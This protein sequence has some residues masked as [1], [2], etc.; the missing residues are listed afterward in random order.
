MMKRFLA[1][2]FFYLSLLVTGQAQ[3]L[4]PLESYPLSAS[5]YHRSRL[6]AVG[7]TLNLPFFDDFANQPAGPASR[8][9]WQR[10]GGALVNNQFGLNPPSVG[11]ATLEGIR[12]NG[13]PYNNITAYG[14][15]DTLT[16]KPLDLQNY[17]PLRD[18]VYLSFYW[19]AGGLAGSPDTYSATRPVFLALEFKQANGTWQEVWRQTGA[20][21][22]TAFQRENIRL[23]D[24]VYFYKGFQ[25]RFRS[26]GVQKGTGDSWN[27]DYI[28]LNQ[29]INPNKRLIEDVAINQRLNSLL[30]RYT[31]MPAWQ[32]LANPAA[33]LND[34]AFTTINNLN[35]QFVP[36]TWR[37]Y[38][39]VAG[40]AQPADTFL[41]GNA[42]VPPLASLLIT[43]TPRAA[44]LPNTLGN[45]FTVKSAL[46]I[47]SR[48]ASAR[49][50]QNDTIARISEF[51][52]YY[53]YDD[54][55]AESNFSLDKVGQRLG[56][57]AFETNIPDGVKGVRVYFT[58]TN[59]AGHQISFRVWDN[60]AEKN[61]PAANAKA[62]VG[63]VIPVID[64]LNQFFDVIFP[65]PAPVS[66]IFYVGWSLSSNVPDFVNIGFD[67][68][69]AASGKIQYNNNG[70]GWAT[71]SGERGALMLRPIMD[72]VTNSEDL[73]DRQ[74]TI[75]VFPNPTT[76]R[77]YL[78]GPVTAWQVT[79]IT[80]KLIKAG[81]VKT[82]AEP[83]LDLSSL[84]D[85]LY[86]IH[87]QTKKQII[88]KKISIRH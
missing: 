88:I 35:Q 71:F 80:G 87:C 4:A 31:A 81:K 82:A 7:D 66:G 45:D 42:A 41:R 24:P 61:I 51:K 47:N 72:R 52:D 60:D 44:A 43:G 38:T 14:S 63:F 9:Y 68:N 21:Q 54:G 59:V 33:E 5:P 29:K 62:Q 57:Y 40:R 8:L 36:I 18:S 26:S 74:S 37:G 55:T 34:S 83:E 30:N 50:R 76:G 58:K 11:V 25:F 86:F 6:S 39:Q 23:L 48:E 12:G 78:R 22:V 65:A 70:T 32:F 15:T 27:L 1:Y 53:A 77:V 79:D 73:I 69:E 10:G 75:T 56:A 67:L 19:Q 16:S 13:L 85:G 2:V 84:A 64:S 3:F 17:Q 28:Y 49:T 20:N 46:F